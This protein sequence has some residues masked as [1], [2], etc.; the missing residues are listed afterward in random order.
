MGIGGWGAGIEKFRQ[1]S[2]V[3]WKE[4]RGEESLWRRIL[5]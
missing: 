5:L 4:G 1:N 2:R 3:L